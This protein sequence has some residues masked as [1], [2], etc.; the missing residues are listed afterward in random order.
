MTLEQEQQI[1]QLKEL[2]DF[3]ADNFG[4]S[5]Q[6]VIESQFEIQSLKSQLET[7]KQSSEDFRKEFVE[8]H[9]VC[10]KLFEQNEK[11]QKVIDEIRKLMKKVEDNPKENPV[12]AWF[13]CS[14]ERI[15][16]EIEE[17]K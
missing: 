16:S 17:K 3:N 2:V 13:F 4:K 14:L 11:L 10:M 5:M 7:W 1:K 6:Q 12:N 8:E 15:L 9:K